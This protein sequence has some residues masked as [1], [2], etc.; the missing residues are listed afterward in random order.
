MDKARFLPVLARFSSSLHERPLKITNLGKKNCRIGSVGYTSVTRA[1][2]QKSSGFFFAL[3]SNMDVLSRRERLRILFVEDH[4]DTADAFARAMEQRG[5]RVQV[6]G[7]YVTALQMGGNCV[8]DL[9]ICDLQLPDGDGSNLLPTL[10]DHC[11]LPG[12]RG[13]I[14]SAC[15][16][17]RDIERGKAAGYEAHLLKPI[18]FEALFRTIEDVTCLH[19]R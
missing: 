3:E 9:L 16:T 11:K 2:H 4:A 13:I 5:Y 1:L 17:A 12:L 10:R 14:F 7:D 18:D 8:Y 19:H 15:G 6:A